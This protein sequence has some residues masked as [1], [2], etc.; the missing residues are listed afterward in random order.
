MH[1]AGSHNHPFTFQL[2]RTLPSS[3]EGAHGYVRYWAKA[4]MDRPWKFNHDTKSA[5]TVICPL[6]LNANAQALRVS[7][8]YFPANI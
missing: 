8:K 3:F 4:C 1:P 6:D 5:F 7:N 2:P